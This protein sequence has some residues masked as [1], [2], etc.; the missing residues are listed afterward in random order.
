MI[1]AVVKT[2]LQE[3]PETCCG[4]K[5]KRSVVGGHGNEYFYHCRFNGDYVEPYWDKKNP[6]C[7]LVDDGE[8]GE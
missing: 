6:N 1:K 2:D 4:C 8:E 5:F 7:P 3:I